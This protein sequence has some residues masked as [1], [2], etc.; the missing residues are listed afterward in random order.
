ME[1]MALL[2]HDFAAQNV[3]SDHVDCIIR[4]A[5]QMPHKTNVQIKMFINSVDGR[6]HFTIFG[7]CATAIHF[8][9]FEGED[10]LEF[11]LDCVGG[12]SREK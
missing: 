6:E 7:M 12:L 5:K 3:S 11:W 4:K 10:G 1:K 2:S 9:D 8:E